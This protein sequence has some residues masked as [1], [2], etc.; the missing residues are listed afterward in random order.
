MQTE[1]CLAVPCVPFA[2]LYTPQLLFT[3]LR[4]TD[5]VVQSLFG[6][7]CQ[8]SFTQMY[9]RTLIS[10]LSFVIHSGRGVQQLVLVGF[11]NRLVVYMHY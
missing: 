1:G 10:A 8:S 6:A 5:L 9:W 7:G 2:P 11:C 4:T 3:A